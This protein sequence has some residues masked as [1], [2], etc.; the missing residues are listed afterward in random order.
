MMRNVILIR[1]AIIAMAI[2]LH[3]CGEYPDCPS[4]NRVAS[5][6]CIPE[7]TESDQID[8]DRADQQKV[9]DDQA[10]THINER[11][12]AERGDDEKAI[13]RHSAEMQRSPIE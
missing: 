7:G 10:T 5:G 2:G 9:V 3:G 6:D 1:A 13:Q 11:I 12:A 4:G 8:Q